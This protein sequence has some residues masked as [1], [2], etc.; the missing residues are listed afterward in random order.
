MQ[1]PFD[2]DAWCIITACGVLA[3]TVDTQAILQR[4]SGFLR[5]RL[6]GGRVPQAS[7]RTQAMSKGSFHFKYSFQNTKVFHAR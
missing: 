6:C 2:M 7:R 5:A 4:G 1:V 3:F